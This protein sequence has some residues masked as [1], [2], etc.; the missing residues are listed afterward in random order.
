MDT[1]LEAERAY[2]GLGFILLPIFFP[3]TIRDDEAIL[4]L[5]LGKNLRERQAKLKE[6]LEC[7]AEHGHFLKD[8]SSANMTTPATSPKGPTAREP[9][10]GVVDGPNTARQQPPGIEMDAINPVTPDVPRPASGNQ[11]IGPKK[12]LVPT[13]TVLSTGSNSTSLIT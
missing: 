10:N 9:P 5:E 4:W 6:N 7:L 8:G 11:V 2:A 1:L 13:S 3:G 12:I